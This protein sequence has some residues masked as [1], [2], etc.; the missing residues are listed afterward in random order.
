M[1]KGLEAQKEIDRLNQARLYG[2]SRIDQLEEDRKAQEEEENRRYNKTGNDNQDED[3]DGFIDNRDE[4]RKPMRRTKQDK[5]HRG[6][7]NDFEE[8]API[9]AYNQNDILSALKNV[10]VASASAKQKK[11]SEKDNAKSKEMLDN[12]FEELDDDTPLPGFSKPPQRPQNNYTEPRSFVNNLMDEEA[13]PL[14]SSPQTAGLD[15]ELEA[16]EAEYRNQTADKKVISNQKPIQGSSRM[17][18]ERTPSAFNAQKSAQHSTHLKDDKSFDSFRKTLYIW[19]KN[20]KNPSPNLEQAKGEVEIFENKAHFYYIDI[21]EDVRRDKGQLFLYGKVKTKGGSFASCCIVIKDMLRTYYIFKRDNENV[22]LNDTLEEVQKK[23]EKR[24]NNIAKHISFSMKPVTDKHYCFELDIARGN[25]ECVRVSYSFALPPLEIDFEGTNYNGIIGSTYKPTELF[26]I[27]NGIKGPSWLNISDFKVSAQKEFSHCEVEMTVE[28]SLDV[29]KMDNQPDPPKFKALSVSLIRDKDG[30]NDIK[31]IAG[32]YTQNYDV[33]NVQAQVSTTP[34]AFVAVSEITPEMKEHVKKVFGSDITFQKTDYAMIQAFLQKLVRLDPDLIIG[35]D[36]NNSFYETLLSRIEANKID[37]TSNL[38]RSRRD[39][40]EMR[41]SLKTFGLKKIRN[42]TFGRM[43]CDT[44]LSSTEIIRETNY[45]LDYLAEKHLNESNIYAFR[46]TSKDQ[47]ESLL[48]MLDEVLMNCHLSLGLCQKF[49]LVQ[50]NK[51][52]TNISGCFW[53]QSFQNLRA[54]RNEML[55][56]HTFYINGFIFPDKYT[57]KYDEEAKKNAKKRDKPKYVG[58]LVLE[59]KAG[60]Y[61]DFIL[62]LDFNSLYPSIIREYKICFTTVKRDYVPIEF[63]KPRDGPKGNAMDTEEPVEAEEEDEL[64]TTGIRIP[65]HDHLSIKDSK[66]NQVLPRIVLNLINMRKAIKK[67]LKNEKDTKRQETLDIKQKAV[68]LIANSIYGCLGFKN[69]RFYA[70][71]MAALITNYGRNILASSS[72]KV[73]EL[74]FEVVYGDTDSLMINSREK[75]LVVAIRKGLEIK[76]VINNSYKTS[77]ILEIEVDGIFRSLLLLKKKKY[78]ADK[79]QNLDEIMKDFDTNRA[80]FAIELKGLDIVR[81][82]WSGLTKTSGEHLVRLILASDKDTDEVV[83]KILQYIRDLK[84]DL[85]NNKIPIDSFTIYKQL[86]KSPDQYKE[87]GQPHVSV[88][89]RMLTR[90]YK[91]EQLLHHFIPYIICK[92]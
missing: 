24:H 40:A 26:L 84:S 7:D 52:L 20:M 46:T 35:H 88:A 11:V 75:E 12:M 33:E 81:R 83:S 6:D 60:L 42:A 71:Q 64:D 61:Q 92:F 56:M 14:E 68:K 27:E 50:L 82:D 67:D 76:K 17:D 28:T 38:S 55:L 3:I 19:N 80:K 5:G 22:N 78:A 23:I 62:L 85:D 69:S 48:R 41:K 45:E 59:P 47:G 57:Q 31:V 29:L 36:V 72:Q 66:F 74:G 18:I 43:V 15:D 34:Y 65:E 8:E 91:N 63:Y 79:L 1:K 25:V 58:G 10:K 9:N 21:Q 13:L 32:L 73:S 77:G 70:K 87:K 54:E 49:Q 30:N 44:H 2:T 90:G 16:L 89:K 51:Q 86:N 37:L 4:L 39:T 53:Y